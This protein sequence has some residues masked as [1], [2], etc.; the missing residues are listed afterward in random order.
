MSHRDVQAILGP[1]GDY[2][3]RAVEFPDGHV[4]SPWHLVSARESADSLSDWLTGAGR[5]S[6][7][8]DGDGKVVRRGIDTGTPVKQGPLENLLWRAKRQWRWFPE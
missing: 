6:V 1:P 8:F 7:A 5:V 2:T 3:T 4:I